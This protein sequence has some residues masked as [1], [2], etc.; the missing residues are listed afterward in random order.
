[1]KIIFNT[2]K[3]ETSINGIETLVQLTTLTQD[4]DL[5][6]SH[7]RDIF[8]DIGWCE[9]IYSYNIITVKGLKFLN[10]CGYMHYQSEESNS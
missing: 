5:I 3:S 6:S 9:K 4:R 7:F 2:E 1:M 8:K 10:D